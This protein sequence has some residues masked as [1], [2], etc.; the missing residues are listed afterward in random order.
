MRN[1]LMCFI[2]STMALALSVAANARVPTGEA[3]MHKMTPAFRAYVR[4]HADLAMTEH[5]LHEVPASITL[6]QGLLESTAG[7]SNHVVLANNH[8]GIK[9]K[10]G[11]DSFKQLAIGSVN[12]SEGAFCKYKSTWWCYRHHSK[13]LTNGSYAHIKG[14]CGNNYKGWAYALKRVGYAQDK[15]YAE[16]LITLIDKYELWRYDGHNS[17]VANPDKFI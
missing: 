15:K 12:F 16:K 3:A 5:S 9:A 11:N 14:Q 8:F 1:C 2:F 4:E 10:F 6:A 17:P 13:L 7:T